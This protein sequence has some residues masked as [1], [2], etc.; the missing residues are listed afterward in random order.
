MVPDEAALERYAEAAWKH[1]CDRMAEAKERPP[2]VTPWAE[3]AGFLREIDR[4]TCSLVAA[5][6]V[7]DAGLKSEADAMELA[8]FRAHLPAILDALH[9]AVADSGYAAQAKP[10]K[11]A[12]EA[13][14]GKEERP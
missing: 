14:S 8:R 12:L 4:S 13:L 7:H 10:F 3:R 5:M 11:A 6:A 1:R 9:G 2:I